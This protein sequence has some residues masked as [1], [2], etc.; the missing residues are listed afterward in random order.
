MKLLRLADLTAK[1]L[2]KRSF[3]YEQ[4][5]R[6]LLPRP[7]KLHSR[8]ACWPEP[9]VDRLI[10]FLITEPAE[11]DLRAFVADLTAQRKGG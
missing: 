4:I 6:G 1:G 10:T 2:G 3:I 5:A 11:G 7:L 9:E 8:L